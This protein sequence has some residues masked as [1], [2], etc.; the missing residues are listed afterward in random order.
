[1]GTVSAKT[2]E[3]FPSGRPM[4]VGMVLFV[5]KVVGPDYGD[6]N[7]FSDWMANSDDNSGNLGH[8]SSPKPGHNGSS[9]PT[10]AWLNLLLS[11]VVATT[12]SKTVTSTNHAS[13]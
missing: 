11:T 10:S 4:V 8:N 12:L 9:T 1:M 13:H 3:F 2:M 5:G 6:Y 7:L